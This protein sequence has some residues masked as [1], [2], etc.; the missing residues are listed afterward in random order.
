[1]SSYPQVLLSPKPLYLDTESYDAKQDRRLLDE[2]ISDGKLTGFIV[3]TTSGLGISVS[4]GYAIIAGQ[5]VA[6]QG[7]Y[8]VGPISSQTLTVSAAHATLPRLDQVIVRVLDH[9]A[10]SSGYNEA[11][12]EI[13]PGTPTSGAT[14][15]NRNGAAS[16]T[17]LQDASKSVLLV[18]DILVTPS[19]ST[20]TSGNLRNRNKRA[21]SKRIAEY[22]TLAARPV[23]ADVP[24]GHLY[25]AT[26]DSGGQ[27]YYTNNG[28]Y[29]RFGAPR[30]ALGG[31]IT[32][33]NF[34]EGLP[35][36]Y[37]DA[38][39]GSRVIVFENG[40]S[41]HANPETRLYPPSAGY[42][43]FWVDIKRAAIPGPFNIFADIWV[44]TSSPSQHNIAKQYVAD[45]EGEA[46]CMNISDLIYLDPSSS[47]LDRIEVRIGC[48]PTFGQTSYV[49]F[50]IIKMPV[51]VTGISQ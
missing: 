2:L 17:T 31:Q 21:R 49:S 24:D 34:Y 6:N 50:G 4:A 37:R 42:Y 26:D 40:D 33:S 19:L 43:W 5:N 51:D 9:S 14:L 44:G 8:R 18:C 32:W 15:D 27:A 28:S 11:R 30:Q 38:S 29:L 1:M 45:D 12:I 13:V 47:S 22:G 39:G 48:T 25:Y 7:L 23:A 16:L 35:T 3:S 41:V 36:Q 20:L 46:D 10:D